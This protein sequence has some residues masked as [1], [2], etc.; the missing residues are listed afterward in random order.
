MMGLEKAKSRLKKLSLKN[1]FIIATV[2]SA[3]YLA[4]GKFRPLPNIDIFSLFVLVT[5]L[6]IVT[7]III[8]KKTEKKEKKV[9]DDV[10]GNSK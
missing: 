6:S 4:I 8:A 10:F 1:A 7:Q 9:E 3:G 5:L 2:V